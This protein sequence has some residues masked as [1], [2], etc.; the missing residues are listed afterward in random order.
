M[1]LTAITQ[2]VKLCAR[3]RLHPNCQMPASTASLIVARHM[4]K[5]VF[6]AHK[7]RETEVHV[8]KHHGLPPSK[9]QSRNEHVTLLDNEMVLQGI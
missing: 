1:V 5:G 8:L 7:I 9:R 3:L 6:F 4:G 2:F